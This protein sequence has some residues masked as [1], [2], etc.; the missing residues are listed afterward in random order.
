[1]TQFNAPNRFM[2]PAS[3]SIACLANNPIFADLRQRFPLTQCSQWPDVVLLNRWRQTMPF[4]FVHNDELSADGRYYEAFIFDTQRIPT[5]SENWH[6]MFGALIWCLFPKTKALLNSLHMAEIAQYGVKQRSKIRNKLT[7]FDECGVIIAIEP[8]AKPQQSLLIAQQWTE[9]FWHARADWWQSI[10]PFVFGHAI[11]EMATK[12]FLGLTAKC[13]FIE[14]PAGFSHWSLTDSYTFLD[15]K[16]SKQIANS[17]LLL[18]NRQLTP[19]PL[20]GIPHWYADNT[21]QVFYGNTEY[22]RPLRQP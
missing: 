18:D 15:E 17:S 9:S 13:W 12:P 21:E 2:P 1:M 19:L 7:L 8:S 14:V 3:W 10:R 22:F 11:Y 16:L 4:Q 6:D 5:R 20:L